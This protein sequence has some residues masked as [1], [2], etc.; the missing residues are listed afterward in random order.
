MIWTLFFCINRYNVSARFLYIKN[1][2]MSDKLPGI[3]IDA[4]RARQVAYAGEHG[5]KT[6]VDPAATRA[7]KAGV[8]ENVDAI[9]RDVLRDVPEDPAVVVMAKK[10]INKFKQPGALQDSGVAFHSTFTECST[11]EGFHIALAAALEGVTCKMQHLGEIAPRYYRIV[12]TLEDLSESFPF[13]SLH[14]QAK[15]AGD[16]PVEPRRV[17]LAHAL[18]WLD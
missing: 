8:V 9:C 4:G 13:V 11:E 7:V 14:P 10:L 15:T 2:F 6:P 12:C 3:G 1:L 17:P 18:Q 16:V 5:F